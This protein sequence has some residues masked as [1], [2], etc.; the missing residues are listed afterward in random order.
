VILTGF[1]ISVVFGVGL[2]LSVVLNRT[3]EWVLMHRWFPDHP[4]GRHRTAL[5]RR[6][7]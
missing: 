3:A 1:A 6:R 4:E 7:T 2:A 5:R